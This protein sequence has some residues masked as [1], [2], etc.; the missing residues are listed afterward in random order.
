M[1][2]LCLVTDRRRLSGA[3]GPTEVERLVCQVEVAAEAGVDLVQVRERDLDG[4]PLAELVSRCLAVVGPSS[5]RLLV[6]ERVDVA[7]AC[8]AHGVHLRS[9][10]MTASRVRAIAPPSF[11]I[12]RS[13]HSVG[14]AAGQTEAGGLDYLLLGA[15]FPPSGK[16]PGPGPLGT[17]A[18]AEACRQT[19]VPVLAIGGVDFSR[20]PAIARIGAA[21]FAAIGL[22]ADAAGPRALAET[23]RQARK[24]FD[25]P[26]APP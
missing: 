5:T 1:S 3:Y 17:A 21:G 24:V 9:D 6:N 11:T 14:E 25:M 18:L 26:P 23:V 13:V 8:G 10:S 22:F 15:I 7:I 20:L 19:A 4:G 16:P 12:G 2:I